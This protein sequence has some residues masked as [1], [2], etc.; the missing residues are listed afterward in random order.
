MALLSLVSATSAKSPTV[1][2]H[3]SSSLSGEVVAWQAVQRWLSQ[4]PSPL[5]HTHVL[6]WLG[7]SPVP[8][9]R[10]PHG[11]PS[12]LVGRDLIERFLAISPST[13]YK[14]YVEVV[15]GQG[16]SAAALSGP[17]FT[18]LSPAS[19]SL[20]Q[21]ASPWPGLQVSAS[22]PGPVQAAVQSWL[23]AWAS[24]NPQTL[25]QATGD[26]SVEHSYVPLYGV[27]GASLA[28]I[29]AAA[30]YGPAGQML[31]EAQVYIAW[32]GQSMAAVQGQSNLTTL[33][34]LVERATTATPVVVAWGPPGSGPTLHPYQNA[35]TTPASS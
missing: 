24:G 29:T 26:P 30:D 11:Q 6:S 2:D 33:D 15:I 27:A 12:A 8:Y 18:S 16:G 1:T 14:V 3:A 4:S 17:F 22:V 20:A 28:G 34:L 9:S 25:L 19:Q 21:N 31:V 7:S 13:W 10:P 35:I 23:A 32:R 5:P